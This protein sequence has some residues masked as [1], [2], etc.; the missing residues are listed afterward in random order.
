V[1]DDCRKFQRN[2]SVAFVDFQKAFDCIS[3]SAIAHCLRFHGIPNIL[4][5][6]VMD[7]YT[8]TSA[9]VKIGQDLSQPFTTSSGVLQGD[10]LAPFLFVI[11]LD[12]V[13]R[14]AKLTGYTLRKRQ[15]SR[16][17]KVCLPFLAFADDIALLSDTATDLQNALNSLFYSAQKVGLVINAHKTNFL[18]IGT[19]DPTPLT[20][21]SGELIKEVNNFAYLGGMVADPDSALSARKASAWVAAIK[22]STL[23][24]ST[25]SEA[26]KVRLFKSAVEP[27][28]FYGLEAIAMT[29]S[30]NTRLKQAHR[31]LAR[32][33]LG[34]HFPEVLRNE[35][36][37]E[38]GFGDAAETLANRRK[39]LLTVTAPDAAL[40][41]V[42]KFPPTERQRRGM[43]QLRT[44][45]D[46]FSLPS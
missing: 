1:I 37:T 20:L 36:L 27:V 41:I 4:I 32:F 33:S 18:H 40:S 9:R 11:V 6:A 17:H 24:H 44:L 39:Q 34:V 46:N 23:F 10:T 13:L 14:D 19:R 8:N 31:S 5:E 38:K 43:S 7:L 45:R 26:T 25:A 28:L 3:R 21:P 12:A 2:V 42:L 29:E 30:R 35:E 16:H 22:L 15:S